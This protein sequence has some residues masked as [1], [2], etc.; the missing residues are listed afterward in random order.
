MKF[1]KILSQILIFHIDFECREYFECLKPAV[2]AKFPITKSLI[3]D[4]G[5]E[6]ENNCFSM[7]FLEIK[8]QKNISEK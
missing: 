7:K 6:I 2:H 3:V 4:Y 5:A 8:I 1:S